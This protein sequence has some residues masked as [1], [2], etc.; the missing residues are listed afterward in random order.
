VEHNIQTQPPSG[1]LFETYSTVNVKEATGTIFLGILA[2]ILLILYNRSNQRY[3]ALV[4]YIT[5]NNLGSD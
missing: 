3:E 5:Q 4:R 1:K 2:V